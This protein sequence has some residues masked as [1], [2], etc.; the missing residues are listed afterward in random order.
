MNK[1]K[2]LDDFKKTHHKILILEKEIEELKKK[3]ELNYK[4]ITVFFTEENFLLLNERKR[5]ENVSINKILNYSLW[6]YEKNK[7]SNNDLYSVIKSASDRLN[8]FLITVH[9]NKKINEKDVSVL[10]K[11]INELQNYNYS[12]LIRKK[13]KSRRDKKINLRLSENNFLLLEKLKNNFNLTSS[14]VFNMI[15]EN[16]LKSYIYNFNNQKIFSLLQR[17][18]N[19]LNQAVSILKKQNLNYSEIVKVQKKIYDIIQ[20]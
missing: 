11:I 7:L 9:K 18:F 2:L 5:I 13:S 12:F 10:I 20:K 4:R 6:D 19:N 3:N 16:K 17:I 1:N 15:I 8:S 14:D